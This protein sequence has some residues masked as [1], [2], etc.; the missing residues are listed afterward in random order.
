MADVT[1]LITQ[2][3]DVQLIGD[4]ISIHLIESGYCDARYVDACAFVSALKKRLQHYIDEPAAASATR[5]EFK[6]HVEW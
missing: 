3:D 2:L 5:A 1:A 6:T 4:D